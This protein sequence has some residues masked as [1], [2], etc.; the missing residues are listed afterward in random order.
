MLKHI[1]T[2]ACPRG[3]SYCITRRLDHRQD[4]AEG[5]EKRLATA[6]SRLAAEGHTEVML[7]GGEPTVAKHWEKILLIAADSF[8]KVFMTTQ[9]KAVLRRP[10]LAMFL[11]GVTYSLHDPLGV[12]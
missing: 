1:L 4:V 3:C 9:E 11:A 6:Y 12:S 8:S 7:T 2:A 10:E 5:W